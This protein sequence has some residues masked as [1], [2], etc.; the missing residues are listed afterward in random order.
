MTL[1]YLMDELKD[2]L[3]IDGDEENPSLSLFLQSAISYLG[4]AGVKKPTDP[5]KKIDGLEVY[6]QYRLGLLMLATHWYENRIVI[7][8]SLAKVEQ[9]PIP[10]GLESMI[11]QLKWVDVE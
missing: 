5:F 3:R 10:Y 4:S 2:Y 11:L 6:S 7:T 8:P 9:T 1:A